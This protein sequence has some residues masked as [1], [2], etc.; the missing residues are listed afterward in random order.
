MRIIIDGQA[1][2]P[3][4]IVGNNLEEILVMIQDEHIPENIISQ[5]Q[6]NGQNYNEDVPHAATEIAREDID[7]L[8]LTTLSAEYIALHFMEHGESVV[9]SLLAAIPQIVEDFRLGDEMEANEH[10]LIFLESLHLIL[11]MVERTC[12]VLNIDFSEELK[13]R[14]SM[15]RNMERL[16]EVMSEMLRIQ[17][18][19]D[20]IYLADLLEYEMAQELQSL[21]QTLPR[22][23]DKRH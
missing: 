7:S 9:D 17:E 11:N 22:L 12:S 18:E 3:D 10:Y 6:V 13:D 2:E 14:P 1:L 8:E 19:N 4:K 21:K 15:D 23:R 20:W 5:V 16:S